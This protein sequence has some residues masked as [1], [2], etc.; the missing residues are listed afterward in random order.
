MNQ[1]KTISRVRTCGGAAVGH[2]RAMPRPARD[3]GVRAPAA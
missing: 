1:N 2:D 3:R